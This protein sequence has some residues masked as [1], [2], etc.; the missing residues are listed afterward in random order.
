M[1]FYG[2]LRSSEYL[3]TGP[4]R[5][6]YGA[7]TSMS[8]PHPAK[9]GSVSRKHNN[10]ASRLGFRYRLHLI[11]TDVAASARDHVLPWVNMGNGKFENDEKLAN[12]ARIPGRLFGNG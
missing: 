11:V 4:G 2:G 7:K 1:A 6:L 8:L 10:T 12:G 3:C 5:G 9:F